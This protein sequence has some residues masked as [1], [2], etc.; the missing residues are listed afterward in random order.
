MMEGIVAVHNIKEIVRKRKMLTVSKNQ[1][2]LARL[3][4]LS[5]RKHFFR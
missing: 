4:A 2:N 3:F 1:L 5:N